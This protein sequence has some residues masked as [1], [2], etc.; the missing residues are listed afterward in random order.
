MQFTKSEMLDIETNI[1]ENIEEYLKQE[2]INISS[3]HF[4]DDLVEDITNV[5]HDYWMDCEICE[6]D[7]YDE[8]EYII[9]NL[10]DVY[11]DFSAIPRRSISYQSIVDDEIINTDEISRKI[12]ALQNLEQPKQKTTEWYEM[13]YNLI[14]ASNIW[15]ALSSVAQRNSLIYEKCKPL[16]LFQSS[17]SSTNTD[18]PL[19]W[20]IKCEPLT[21]MIYEDMFQTRVG[22]FG[23]I[24]HPVYNFIG[25]SPDGINIDPTNKVRFGRML[26]I[27]NVVN[28]DITGTPKEEYWVQCQTQMETCDSDDCDFVETR[29]KEHENKEE[30]Y[31][32]VE[33][34][35]KGVILHFM[36]RTSN[37]TPEKISENLTAV[38]SPVYK[39]MPL[40]VPRNEDEIDSWIQNTRALYNSE[41]ILFKTIYWYLDEI[42]CVLI[43]RNRAWFQAAVPI[44][45]DTWATILKERSSGYEHR[46]SK[47]R[48]PKTD[49][50]I[51]VEKIDNCSSQ[52]IINMP[53]T[54][55]ICLVK[56]DHGA[57]DEI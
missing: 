31:S 6:E 13:R 28:R 34:E 16:N 30:F 19:H 41:L 43:P 5:F 42:S 44:I 3:P 22:D 27:K 12:T 29:I 56:L 55:S 8:I 46:A 9:E 17:H 47:K 11:L 7:D 36:M 35:Y 33:H 21:V 51:Q 2:I 53:L 18:G 49:P 10:L 39:Y 52:S 50:Q 40:D 23:C 48:V 4:Y 57:F 32:D 26:E 37:M 15:K 54:N 14:T 38:N 1:Y 24:R 25:A 45:E 20:G